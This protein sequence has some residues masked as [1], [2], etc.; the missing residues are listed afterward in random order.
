LSS[1]TAPLEVRQI[2]R[3]KYWIVM[4]GFDFYV[5]KPGGETIHVPEG[6]ITD[7]A[8]IPRFAWPIIGHPA[9]EYAQAAALHDWLYS[10]N[11]GEQGDTYIKR[12]RDVCDDIF[13]LAMIVLFVK[14]WKRSVM[15]RIV[16]WFGNGGWGD[17]R[18]PIDLTPEG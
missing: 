10:E 16:K 14:W 9:G 6:F 13:L 3:T 7:F 5:D 18:K 11:A 4:R 12:P 15:H 17:N 1:F 8:S 2:P